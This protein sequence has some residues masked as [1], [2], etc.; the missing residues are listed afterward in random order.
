MF[1]WEKTL[2][3]FKLEFSWEIRY[4]IILNETSTVGTQ[5]IGVKLFEI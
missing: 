3:V 1:G 4:Y 2:P 5:F